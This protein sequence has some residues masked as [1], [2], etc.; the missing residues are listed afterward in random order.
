MIEHQ[1]H[2]YSCVKLPDDLQ[3]DRLHNVCY[4]ANSN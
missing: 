4:G 1:I 3:L 2:K